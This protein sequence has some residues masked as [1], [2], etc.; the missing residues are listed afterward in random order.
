MK[1]RTQHQRYLD[2]IERLKIEYN[3][4]TKTFLWFPKS[5]WTRKERKHLTYWLCFAERKIDAFDADRYKSISF[6]WRVIND[7]DVTVSK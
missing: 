3:D 1:W 2:N 5:I 6:D 7:H 4:W